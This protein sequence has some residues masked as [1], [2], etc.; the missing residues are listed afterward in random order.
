M[1]K[2][3]GILLAVVIL[4]ITVLLGIAIKSIE[5]ELQ[6]LQKATLFLLDEVYGDYLGELQY[7]SDE[8]IDPGG[9]Y[10][11]EKRIKYLREQV[12]QIESFV[13]I[14]D[15]ERKAFDKGEK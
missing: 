10:G 1:N 12:Q 14:L 2:S 6:T 13:N 4:I 7:L 11:S 3:T 9:F 15:P 8:I 5:Q